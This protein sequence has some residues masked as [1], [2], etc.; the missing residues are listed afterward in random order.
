MTNKKNNL[1]YNTKKIAIR[2][3]TIPEKGYGN[4]SRCL[5]IAKSLREKNIQ[6]Y[7]LVDYNRFISKI[8]QKNN[9][10]FIS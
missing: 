8:L 2:C 3:L 5:N 4:F 6:I 7:F 10:N 1:N 9:F